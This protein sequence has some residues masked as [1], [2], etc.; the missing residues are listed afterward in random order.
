MS[1]SQMPVTSPTELTLHTVFN[2]S[3]LDTS[4]NS[5][6]SVELLNTPYTLST[7]VYSHVVIP[8]F[9]LTGVT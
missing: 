8:I 4:C 9:E 1:G 7:T 5:T 6:Q 2:Q 3:E